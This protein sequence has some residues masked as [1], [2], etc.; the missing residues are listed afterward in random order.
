MRSIL[1][2][3]IQECE[4]YVTNICSLILL[5]VGGLLIDVFNSASTVLVLFIMR[6]LL[7]YF[8]KLEYFFKYMMPRLTQAN[9]NRLGLKLSSAN[10][11]CIYARRCQKRIQILLGRC[12]TDYIYSFSLYFS[13]SDFYGVYPPFHGTMSQFQPF[14][15]RFQGFRFWNMQPW[16]SRCTDPGQ[17]L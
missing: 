8:G 17:Q 4:H 5:Y 14:L 3:F 6:V 10:R 2:R 11:V 16:G 1:S 12:L 9:Q 13:C 7:L 15:E